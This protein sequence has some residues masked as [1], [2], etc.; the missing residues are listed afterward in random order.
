MSQKG[1]VITVG[2]CP[3]SSVQTVAQI[4]RGLEARF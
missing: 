3:D 2:W 1:K 4:G